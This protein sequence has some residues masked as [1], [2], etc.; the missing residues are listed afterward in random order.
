MV[1]DGHIAVI[2]T[3]N[4]DPR[5]ANLN[6]ECITVIR[7]DAI[8]AGVL[9]GMNVE[10]QPENAWETTPTF[11][12]DAQAGLAKRFK[13]WIRRVEPGSIL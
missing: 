6:T 5:S 8:A 2:G 10:F 9:A 13:A 4:L 11:N 7:S 3:S 12:P 1:I